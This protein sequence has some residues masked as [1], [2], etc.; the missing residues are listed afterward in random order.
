M[1][2]PAGSSINVNVLANDTDENDDPLTVSSAVAN[3][4]SSVINAR[5]EISYT[6]PAGIVGADIILYSV[7]R[8]Q[9]RFG[10][11]YANDLCCYTPD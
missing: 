9:R 4:G 2:N 3:F 10:I 5:V 6:P 11:R 8:L 1:A 7:T